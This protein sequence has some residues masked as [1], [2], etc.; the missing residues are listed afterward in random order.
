LAWYTSKVDDQAE[1]DKTGECDDFDK[2]EPEFDLA[3]PLDTEAVDRDDLRLNTLLVTIRG[4]LTNAM[5]M[6]TQAAPL[7]EVFQYRITKE[8]ATIWLGLM[9]R[10]LQR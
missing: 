2:R 9:M 1:E 7:I 10:Y 8:P 5:K 6:V 3:E 4:A